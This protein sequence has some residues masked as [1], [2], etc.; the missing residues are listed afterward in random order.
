MNDRDSRLTD[1]ERAIC[2]ALRV[3]EQAYLAQRGKPLR[4]SITCVFGGRFDLG[5]ASG[6]LGRPLPQMREK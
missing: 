5:D 3:S 1:R 2:S 4:L 6:E